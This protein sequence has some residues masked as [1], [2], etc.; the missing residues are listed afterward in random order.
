MKCVADENVD[1]SIV[2]ALRDSGHDVWYVAEE[3]RGIE[4]DEVL[5]KAAGENALLLTGDKD[6]GDLV[7]RQARRRAGCFS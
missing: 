6:F 4:D 7:F 3:K 5:Q 1:S 2:T